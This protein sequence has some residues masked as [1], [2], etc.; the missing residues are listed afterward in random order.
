MNNE[1]A[2]RP[3]RPLTSAPK[4][5][6]EGPPARTRKTGL[7]VAHFIPGIERH[8]TVDLGTTL[9]LHLASQVLC[10]RSTEARQELLHAADRT[11]ALSSDSARPKSRTDQAREL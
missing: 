10:L 8:R 3:M 5:A 11:S 1:R 6:S 7:A 2:A 4:H 9:A